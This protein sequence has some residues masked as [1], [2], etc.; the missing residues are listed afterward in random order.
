MVE[1]FRPGVMKRFGI[2]YEQVKAVNPEVI[3][4]SV[5]GFGQ[6][7]PLQPPAGDGPR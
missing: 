1:S 7:G 3:Y 2:G 6:D 5:T 4:L